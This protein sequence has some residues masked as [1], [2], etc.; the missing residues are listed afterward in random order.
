[1]AHKSTT[2]AWVI[3]NL[4]LATAFGGPIFGKIALNTSV[5]K[6]AS[7]QER[8]LVVQTAWNKYNRLNVAAHIGFG[9]T[10]LIGRRNL[11]KAR[12]G[13]KTHRLVMAKDV[14][15]AGAIVTGVLNAVASARMAKEFPEG[16][17]MTNGDQPGKDATERVQQYQRY[18]R[19]MGPLNL[20][21]VGLSIAIGPAIARA[22]VKSVRKN[23]A[24]KL[25]R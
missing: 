11:L 17:P 16:A 22:A 25:F 15:V 5:E 2:T 8:G 20:A 4:S 10:W 23:L 3:H 19:V 1:M 13:R 7:E 9:L 18:F 24:S 21:L 14:L 6:I 12:F